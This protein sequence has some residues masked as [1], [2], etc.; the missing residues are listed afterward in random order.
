MGMYRCNRCDRWYDGDEVS[1]YPDPDDE[2]EL[3]CEDCAIEHDDD[4]D[5]ELEEE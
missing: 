5:Y 1:C 3:I 4:D 2:L